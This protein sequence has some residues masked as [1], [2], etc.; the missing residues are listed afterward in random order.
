MEL[1]NSI[2]LD[3]FITLIESKAL[4]ERKTKWKILCLLTDLK[5]F[6]DFEERLRQFG[7]KLKKNRY[8][9]EIS[10]EFK[11]INEVFKSYIFQFKDLI[12]FISNERKEDIYNHF[13][14]DF[15]RK[16]KNIYYLWIP[17][18]K[19][20]DLIE[21]FENENDKILVTEFHA[22]RDRTDNI[23]AYFREKRDRKM[24]Y[25]GLDGLQ[26]IKELRYYYGVR[27]YL[28]DINI[29]DRCSFRINKDGFF[30]YDSGDLNFLLELI[31]KIQ[32]KIKYI[33]QPTILSHYREDLIENIKIPTLNVQPIVVK[34]KNFKLDTDNIEILSD[35]LRASGFEIFNQ[36]IIEGSIIFNCDIIDTKKQA[37]FNI[38]SGG[39]EMIITPQ[40]NTTFDTIYSFLE[41]LSEQIDAEIDCNLY[42]HSVMIEE[43][44]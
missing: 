30:S 22:E 15:V 19:I 20:E 5:N 12:Y 37:I 24:I 17:K 6:S 21:D 11:E 44:I 39:K 28:V 29:I 2:T 4:L 25:T 36:T 23:K 42:K 33:L 1:T 34:F 10:K 3:K 7:F 38:S 35:V 31:G 41:I 16:V 18:K 9:L 13:I 43:K 27:P 32:D 14:R 40:Y 26:V 8:I